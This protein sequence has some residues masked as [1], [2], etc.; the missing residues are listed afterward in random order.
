M[1]RLKEGAGYQA[2]AVVSTNGNTK[3]KRHQPHDPGGGT[4][5]LRLTATVMWISP[6]A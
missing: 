6:I 5:K 2:C 4:G 3:H 1:Q